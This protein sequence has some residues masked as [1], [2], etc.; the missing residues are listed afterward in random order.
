ML[1][2]EDSR[3]QHLLYQSVTRVSSPTVSTP[4]WHCEW[5]AVT[6]TWRDLHLHGL[7]QSGVILKLH[8]PTTGRSFLSVCGK[9]PPPQT[10][11]LPAPVVE[12]MYFVFT[13]M[14]GESYRS[15]LRSLLSCL[16]DVFRA[17][18]LCQHMV[19]FIQHSAI[20]T[21]QAELAIFYFFLV[22]FLEKEFHLSC[23]SMLTL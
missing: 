3:T 5:R 18:V 17:F 23:M 9:L 22:V 2:W 12:F 13:R 19:L 11:K 4:R 10:L 7:L 16:C 21:T 20:S 8:T 6:G 1:V 14:P 15:R